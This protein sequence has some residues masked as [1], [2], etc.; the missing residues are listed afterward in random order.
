MAVWEVFS[1]PFHTGKKE[2]EQLHKE[3]QWGR[4]GLMDARDVEETA[5]PHWG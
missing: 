2:R 3:G 1:L 4:K 5:G